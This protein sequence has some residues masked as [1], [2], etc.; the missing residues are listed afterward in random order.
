MTAWKANLL[1]RASG[2]FQVARRW[3]SPALVSEGG[4]PHQLLVVTDQTR[5]LREEELAAW[6]RI[7]RVLGH[8][9]NNSLT[10]IKSI[11]GSLESMVSRENCL[12]IEDDM[13]RGLAIIASPLWKRWSWF[14]SAYAR[15]A[16]PRCRGRLDWM[17]LLVRRAASLETRQPS[18]SSRDRRPPFRATAISWNKCSL[19][20]YAMRR[21]R[22]QG[23][24]W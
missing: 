11:A 13:K 16:K 17:W 24:Q 14:M 7:V 15:L 6:Q 5:P 10:P 8:E 9:L 12:R 19:I 20:L 2:R 21:R 3:E 22:R 18:T 23:D 4:L 1:R